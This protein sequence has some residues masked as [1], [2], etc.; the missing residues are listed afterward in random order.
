MKLREGFSVVHAS[1]EQDPILRNLFEFYLHDLA[2]W[3]RFDQLPDGRYT[4]TIDQYWREG[5]EVYL[6]YAEAIPIGFGLI[7]PAEEWLPGL[8][9]YDMDEFF[10]VRRHRR[11]GIGE[12]FA[13]SLWRSH[14]GD[15]LVRVFQPNRPALPFWRTAIS[16]FTDDCFDEEIRERKGHDWSYFRFSVE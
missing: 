6:L 3:F 13:G 5:H 8:D 1:H 2:E 14:P 9:A 15:W 7:G 11:A 10:I 16:N 12:A 4:H